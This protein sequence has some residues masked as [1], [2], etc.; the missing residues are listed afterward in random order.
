ML[1][2]ASGRSERIGGAAGIL[3][4]RTA[5]DVAWQLAAAAAIAT[6]LYLLVTNAAQNMARQ[7]IVSGFGYLGQEAGYEVGESFI[8]HSARASYARTLLVGLLNTLYVAA[9]GIVLATILGVFV[10]IARVSPNWLLQRLSGIYVEV[11]RNT[12]LLLQIVFWYAVMRQLPP[13]RR[14]FQPVEGVFLSNRGLVHPVP[15]WDPVHQ[16]MGVALVLGLLAALIWRMWARRRQDRTGIR[17]PV[18]LPATAL[19]L[20]P[21]LVVWA[22]A[23]APLALDVPRLRAFNFQGG[24]THSPELVALVTGLVAYAA[25]FIGEVVRSGI[26][27]VGSGQREAARALGLRDGPTLRLVVLP[28]ALRVIVP[29]LTSQYLNIVKDSSLAVWIGY[30]DFVAVSNTALNQTGQ[31]VESIALMMAVYLTI[32]LSISLFMNWYNRH[33]ALRR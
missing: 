12:P 33:V 22:A 27:A 4:N 14:A 15:S 11:F 7:G 20:L 13:P 2:E 18:A 28:Q 17:P 32:S 29:P 9:L 26:Q 8:R 5:R 10:G 3:G 31:A 30:P 6:V 16:W 24:T 25:A 19:L 21:P 23:G 1:R